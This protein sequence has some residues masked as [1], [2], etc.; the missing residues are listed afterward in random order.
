MGKSDAARVEGVDE[1]LN[2]HALGG[3]LLDSDEALIMS[4]GALEAIKIYLNVLRVQLANAEECALSSGNQLTASFRSALRIVGGTLNQTDQPE[5]VK[6]I[7]HT[8]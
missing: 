7:K 2:L 5:R 6:R 4:T 1:N 3:V 8:A